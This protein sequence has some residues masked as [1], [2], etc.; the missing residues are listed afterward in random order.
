MRIRTRYIEVE[1]ILIFEPKTNKKTIQTRVHHHHHGWLHVWL[2]EWMNELVSFGIRITNFSFFPKFV[3]RR[4]FIIILSELCRYRWL[5]SSRYSFHT[6]IFIFLCLF[7]SLV[8]VYLVF[9]CLVCVFYT[10]FHQFSPNSWHCLPFF[11]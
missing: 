8:I 4:F 6:S 11:L 2:D 7:F 9:F 10:W 1:Y 5:F 3:G